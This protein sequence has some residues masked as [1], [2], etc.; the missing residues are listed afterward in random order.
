MRNK[1]ELATIPSTQV[2]MYLFVREL[3]LVDGHVLMDV[4]TKSERNS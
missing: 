3:Q 4:S 2:F 1:Q